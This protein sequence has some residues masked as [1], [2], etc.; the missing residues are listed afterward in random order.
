MSKVVLLPLWQNDDMQMMKMHVNKIPLMAM[1]VV[2]TMMFVICSEEFFSEKK[3]QTKWNPCHTVV[4]CGK[5][6][7]TLNYGVGI[8]Y[9]KIFGTDFMRL[10]NPTE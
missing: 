10:G 6:Q 2:N 3:I 7:R 5:I 8:H 9:I 1:A 4:M